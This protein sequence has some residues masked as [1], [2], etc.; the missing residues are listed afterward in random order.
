MKEEFKFKVGDR[1]QF[2]T[3]KEMKEEYGL[4]NAGDIDFPVC[5]VR[6]MKHLC[7]TFATIAKIDDGEYFC[8]LKD[9]TT[10]LQSDVDWDYSIDMLKP[11]K[12]AE[13]NK[14]FDTDKV[15]SE[16]QFNKCM[17]CKHFDDSDLPNM[18][19][20]LSCEGINDGDFR[21][22]PKNPESVLRLVEH[23]DYTIEQ[24]QKENSR[25]KVQ[26]EMNGGEVQDVE[27][28]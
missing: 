19:C 21:Y 1:V 27:R 9:F 23:L 26:L 4:D 25:L 7:G 15:M 3:W 16:K 28:N 13:I 22:C 6:A 12:V 11:A 8:E 5:F 2:K 18:F 20:N 17:K 24:L 10:K 14:D